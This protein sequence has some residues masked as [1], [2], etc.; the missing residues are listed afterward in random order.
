LNH[1]EAKH[2]VNGEDAKNLASLEFAQDEIELA[3]NAKP[4]EAGLSITQGHYVDT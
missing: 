2:G 1:A 4:P 3:A